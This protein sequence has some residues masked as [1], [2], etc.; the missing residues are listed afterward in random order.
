[1]KNNDSIGDGRGG[2]GGGGGGGFCFTTTFPLWNYKT[3]KNLLVNKTKQ[4]QKTTPPQKKKT[5]KNKNEKTTTAIKVEK[6]SC[7]FVWVLC[8]YTRLSTFVLENVFLSLPS[9]PLEIF[10]DPRLC[11]VI[12]YFTE[13]TE[14]RFLLVYQSC[15]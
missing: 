1:M 15:C 9:N 10:C 2:G 13:F 4:K 6:K 12:R 7:M 3:N 11:L 8:V 5:P 14:R